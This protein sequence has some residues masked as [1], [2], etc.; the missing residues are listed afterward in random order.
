MTIYTA[1][2]QK[3]QLQTILASEGDLDLDLSEVD[4]LDTAGLQ[5]LI[6]LKRDAAKFGKSIRFSLHSPAVLET[7]ELAN[8][9]GVFGDQLVIPRADGA[10]S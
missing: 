3:I 4:E 5:L 2:E 10:R 6:W 9:V 8:L 7:L 1:A